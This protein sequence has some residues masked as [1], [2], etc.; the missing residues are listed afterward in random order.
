MTTSTARRVVALA[1]TAAL[2]A[3]TPHAATASPAKSAAGHANDGD[4]SAE[5]LAANT[6]QP[7]S[8]QSLSR[9]G[10]TTTNIS[11][12]GRDRISTIALQSDGKILAAGR[13]GQKVGLVRY[14]TNGS[15]DTSFGT[16]G[17]VVIDQSMSRFDESA[18]PILV[19]VQ[20]DGK[21]LVMSSVYLWRFDSNGARDF[22]FG[23]G[24]QA[25][26]EFFVESA[27]QQSD[28]KI[29]V[30]GRSFVAG[31]GDG[32]DFVVVRYNSNGSLDT[33]FDTDGKTTTDIGEND[34][35]LSV[36]VQSDGKIVGAGT[37]GGDFAVVRYN[38]NGSLDTSF[39]TDGKT[40]T[41]IGDARDEARSVTVQSDGKIVVAGSG[42]GDFAV[43]RYNTNGGLDTSFDTDGKLITDLNFYMDQSALPVA[44]QSDGK[45]VIA[46]TTT[47]FGGNNDFATARFNTDGSLD[48]SFDTDGKTTT[49]IG[50]SSFDEASA[51][52][53]QSDGKIVVAGY[54]GNDFAVV[55]YNSSGSLDTAFD[56]DGKVITAASTNSFD[57]MGSAALQSDGKIVVAG[58]SRGL[59]PGFGL[60]IVVARYDSDGSLDTSFDTDGITTTQLD[61][62]SGYDTSLLSRYSS[63][64]FSVA[65][66]S[67]GKIVVAGSGDGDFAVV[68]YNSN[69]SLD[70]SFDTD[71]KT[72]TDIGTSS[73]DEA[74]AVALQSDGK[75]V[76]AGRSFGAG[77]SGSD[78]AV[79]RYNSNGNLDTSFDTD[80]KTTTDIGTSSIDEASAVALQSDGKIVVAGRSFVAG[81]GDGGDFVVVRYNSNGSLDTSFDTD[82]KTTT[83]IGTSSIDEASAVALQSDGKIVVAGSGDGGDFAVV[84]YNSNGSLDT[85]FDTDGKTT[86]NLI[87]AGDF[88]GEGQDSRDHAS[89]VVL[90]STGRIIVAGY[91][92]QFLAGGR[93]AVVR[94]SSDGG[95]DTGLDTNG[96]AFPGI[97]VD[98]GF[99][100]EPEAQV[101]LQSDGKIV[102]AGESFDGDDTDS[103][104]A[105]VRL[106]AGG[107]LDRSF[108]DVDTSLS[109]GMTVPGAPT[110]VS[111]RA[112]DGSVVVS[113]RWPS[114][115][116]SSAITGYTV[117]A[118]PGGATCT[119]SGA[120]S[121]MVIGLDNG[122]AY[123]FT[124]TAQNSAG[125][126][127]AS[128]P[129]AEVTPRTVPD[130]PTAVSAVP[131]NAL[132]LVS[133]Q[134]PGFDGGSDVTG[135][136]ATASPGGRSCT[137]ADAA[138]AS[139]TVTGLANGTAYTFTVTASNVAGS[140]AASAASAAVV[141]KAVPATP[142]RVSVEPEHES[143]VVSWRVPV[144]DGG[145][146][147]TGYEAV[148]DPGGLT[149]TA[150]DPA[151]TTCTI[152]GLDNGTA[153]TVTVT[154]SNAA[155]PSPPSAPAG[156]VTPRTVPDAPVSVTATEY[157][158][159][160]SRIEWRAPGYD[161]GAAISGYEA[162]SDPGGHS[163]TTD[164]AAA[165]ACTVTG[166]TNGASYMFT[167]TAGNE[168]GASAASA[169]SLEVTPAG[170][171][172]APGGVTATSVGGGSL[173][174][175][176][177][178]PAD[179][180]GPGIVSYEATAE[181]GGQA[182]AAFS[183][184]DCTITGLARGRAYEVTV[185]AENGARRTSPASS[186]VNAVVPADAPGAPHNVRA[187]GGN[188][189][190][191]VSW[192]AP[193]DAGADDAIIVGYTA[194][195][196]AVGQT[197][198]P[199][200][201]TAAGGT[202]CTITG[203]TNGI[204]Y[205]ITVVAENSYGLVSPASSPAASVSP[206]APIGAPDA[207]SGV[208][209]T[210][211]DDT[212]TIAW[213]VPT[214]SAGAPPGSG[215][216]VYAGREDR[217]AARL[218]APDPVT[219]YEVSASPGPGRCTAAATETSCTIT[220]LA[221]GVAYTFIVI[222]NNNAGPSTAS[223]PSRPASVT[224][225]APGVPA[226]TQATPG[227]GWALVQWAAPASDGG[228][229]IVGYTA[230]SAPSGRTCTASA[231]QRWCRIE[232]LANGAHTLTV[233]A[234]NAR[235]ASE[236][237]QPTAEVWVTAPTAVRA[238]P[239]DPPG[240]GEVTVTWTAPDTS[241]ST[242]TITGYAATSSPGQRTCT[243]AA[244][245]TTCTV[246]GLVNDRVYTFTVTAER[247]DGLKA[248]SAPSNRTTPKAV[249]AP[250]RRRSGGGGGGGGAPEP[251]PEP[252]S[253]SDVAP[254]DWHAPYV[255][256]IARLGVTT[257]YPDG[258]YRPTQPITRAQMAVF[259][260]RALDLDP[261]DKLAGRFDDVD[262]EAWYAPYIERIA[263]LGISVGC[264]PRGT[265]YCPDDPVTR[266]QMALFLQRAFKLPDADNDAPTFED[267]DTDHYAYNA[268][269]AIS[270]ADITTGC[271]TD[272][273]LYCGPRHVTRAQMAAFLSRVLTRLGNHA[274]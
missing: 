31:S 116:G 4:P 187:T 158:D 201:C 138:V 57:I 94:Y 17:R 54:S 134:A 169:P 188:G 218:Q 62:P 136:R 88:S 122:T 210:V 197:E 228:A 190:A 132:A 47:P 65:L 41:D 32:G 63:H 212:A 151:A 224:A 27:A 135:Y 85:S 266:S 194:T 40:T 30:A 87:A 180:G 21:I 176:W 229:A 92:H 77:T 262:L 153:Y 10:Y 209:A 80:G 5:L 147:I 175:S 139:C 91:G 146:E 69:G 154:A 7:V 111:A 107:S 71:G 223:Q 271:N 24:G 148:A 191:R 272:P 202:A 200:T 171:P 161:G 193:A 115:T 214:A 195:A 19:L 265:D 39:D 174:V 231:A 246:T 75:I 206:Q 186:P 108:G 167:V 250:P 234:R 34:R 253:F 184:T 183:A 97:I 127:A 15:L 227:G 129:S 247:S 28:G 93:L 119:T 84:R 205:E 220:G 102:V 173:E 124:V 162:V 252:V 189:D 221:P 160:Q 61:S 16:G 258:S 79:V 157:E 82:G 3:V 208:T 49:D 103:D 254:D 182:C 126:S 168:A 83:D 263:R 100:D 109:P 198:D 232:G 203:L 48:T 177:T 68:R 239:A 264:N 12:D 13:T 117:T 244:A 178:E 213:T 159:G 241:A 78:F 141:P 143:V 245:D 99:G 225:A 242:I 172:D 37:S 144:S 25:Y 164:D 270:A 267:I 181:P 155:G 226:I 233:T 70:T 44:V 199:H 156:P 217:A 269:E 58:A 90:D 2:L 130:A 268:V 140:S 185:T 236:P 128:L 38:S 118:S 165:T 137:S 240:A 89:S 192:A 133:W 204:T 112:G 274:S 219:S 95:L 123:T 46:G 149:C 42:D 56:S 98:Y 235:G 260:V 255:E 33:S 211:E 74:S 105:V 166:L 257:G 243:A 273:P 106:S 104:F 55:R 72:T 114:S 50:T 60:G 230:T 207:P 216:L 66:Q 59:R 113:W 215:V 45:L 14:N 142:G 51:V 22:S 52:A 152:T 237:S 222:A 120:T 11:T 125:S 256:H 53:L 259:L 196:A 1:V 29:V 20:S 145:S 18:E 170:A 64:T 23:S 36:T 131:G 6:N 67:D 150:S 163:C 251:E 81:S 8:L 76:V 261:V 86:T 238:E 35:A 248:A 73:I 179:T 110:G 121:C 43:V 101:A 96:I 249:V 9:T 26:S